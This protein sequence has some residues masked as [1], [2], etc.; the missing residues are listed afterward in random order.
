MLM[1]DLFAIANLLVL[2]ITDEL[3]EASDLFSEK[4]RLHECN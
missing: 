2:L 1:R 3:Q 4:L